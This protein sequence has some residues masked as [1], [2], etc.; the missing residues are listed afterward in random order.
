M[1][2]QAKGVNREKKPSKKGPINVAVIVATAPARPPVARQR[3]NWR[4]RLQLPA[5]PVVV[6][7][8]PAGPRPQLR[9]HGPANSTTAARRAAQAARAADLA[10]QD[11]W[12]IQQQAHD[13]AAAYNSGQRRSGR[14]KAK[15]KK[16]IDEKE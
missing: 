12:D 6:P 16:L 4:S 3:V 1:G 14:V 8:A 2:R 9:P 13:N 15:P 11:A 7:P 10:A 5:A